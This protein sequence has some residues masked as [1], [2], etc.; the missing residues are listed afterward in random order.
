MAEIDLSG[1]E[2]PGL[3]RRIRDRLALERA[4]ATTIDWH[5]TMSGARTKLRRLYPA[6]QP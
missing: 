3:R 1:L 6:F 2:R 4:V 5:C